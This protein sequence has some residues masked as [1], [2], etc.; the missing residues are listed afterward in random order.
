MTLEDVCLSYFIGFVISCFL[1]AII[2]T[3]CIFIFGN[4]EIPDESIR[5]ILIAFIL[6]NI[7]IGTIILFKKTRR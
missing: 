1:L 5:L 7:S 6:C 4:N 2:L 3:F